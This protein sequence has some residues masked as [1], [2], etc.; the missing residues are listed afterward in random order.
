MN[1]C[2]FL[3]QIIV[4]LLFTL[5][6]FRLGKTALG[7]WICI[8]ALCA[9]LFVLKQT[10]LFGFHVTCSDAFAIGGI[11]SINL[12]QEHYGIKAAK[13]TI[14]PCFYFMLFFALLAQI[15]LLYIASPQDSTQTAY[16]AI[17][18]PAPR[19]FLASLFTFFVVQRIDIYLFNL[20]KTFKPKSSFAIR[21]FFSLIFSQLLDTILFTF[22]GLYGLVYSLYDMI[23]LSF[24]IKVLAICV[25]FP[26][27]CLSKRW[28]QPKEVLIQ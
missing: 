22:I 5:G 10:V 14:M 26:L 2:I 20:M 8:Q 3:F 16:Q 25:L 11:L 19:L 17:L 7:T 12:L 24:F 4:V 1:E 23:F 18:S 9:N 15:H 27:T 28:I 13:K 6:S 21:T